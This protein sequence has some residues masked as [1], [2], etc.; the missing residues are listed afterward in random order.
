MDKLTE[1]EHSKTEFLAFPLKVI[2][3]PFKAFK[4]IIQNPDI[5]G[6]VLIVGLVLLAT[7]GSYYA[8]SAKIFLY[9]NGTLTSLLGSSMFSGFI[10]SVLVEGVLLFAENWLLYAGILFLVMRVFGQKGGVWRPFFT[11]VGYAL[12]ITIVQSVA[13]A[14]LMATLPEIRFSNLSIWPPSTENEVAIANAGIQ[15]YWSPTPVYQ[16][17]VYLN[18]PLLNIIDVWLVILSVIMV[19]TFSESTWR[20]ATVISVTAFVLRFFLKIFLGF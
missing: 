13:S 1:A 11:I 17:I 7:A 5:K 12:S 16:A 4:E 20:K 18:S 14:I 9:I 6:I 15:K 19:H 8:Y 3:S 10:A 2:V